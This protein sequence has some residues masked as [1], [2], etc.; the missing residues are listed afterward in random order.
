[1]RRVLVVAAGAVLMLASG[2]TSSGDTA[3][4]GASGPST[5]TGVGPTTS[6]VPPDTETGS[7]T[8]EAG[9]SP[10]VE[11]FPEADG[12]APGVTDDTVKIGVTYVDL[13]PVIAVG[14]NI[15][16]GD[17]EAA[18]LTRVEQINA[19]GGVHGRQLEL[20]FAPV[21]PISTTSAEEACIRLVEDED[22]FLT[23]GFFLDDGMMCQLETYQHPVIGG[24]MTQELLSRAGAP[25]LTLE[26]GGDLQSDTIRAYAADGLLDAPF[27]V[28][29]IDQATLDSEFL[30]LLDELGLEPVESAVLEAA[31]DDAV[32]QVAQTEVI[33][34]RFESEG[35]ET[36][37][38]VG[39]AGVSWSRGIESLGYRP[40]FLGTD[41]NSMLAY[42]MAEEG[43]DATVLENAALGGLYGPNT[44]VFAEPGMQRCL[45]EL[46]EAGLEVPDPGGLGDEDPNPFVS[47][48][49]A[50][51][52]LALVEALLHAAG[53]DLNHGTL[54]LAA[55][56]LG[57][58]PIPGTPDPYVFGPPPAADGDPTVYL[59]AFDPV[60]EDFVIQE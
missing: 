43:Y 22:V 26:P 5:A 27:A 9:T 13:E 34:Q 32:E 37:L 55:D 40:R 23:V 41:L 11:T 16:H 20:V 21:D 30:P 60:A 59:Y 46:A 12:P 48:S 35:V 58:V 14:I 42:V 10:P 15:D 29:S 52:Y 51:R 47:A 57:E 53:P 45:S 7:A 18:Y 28:F 33:A 3:T 25:W 54:A 38:V 1:M 39:N 31:S 36:V 19:A 2:C 8:T 6:A 24:A 49:S 17:Y 50:C 44:A 4:D 56:G